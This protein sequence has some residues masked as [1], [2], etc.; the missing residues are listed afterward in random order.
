[1]TPFEVLYG[2]RCCT[3]LNWIE[4]GEN[5]IF[6]PNLIYEAEATIRHIQDNLK[7]T[8][9]CQESYANKRRW[10][11]EFEVGDHVYLRVSSTKGVK[12]FGMKGHLALRYI[13]P[14]P[15]LEKYGPVTYKLELPRAPYQD[16]GLK[17]SCHY[18]QYR[19]QREA[20]RARCFNPIATFPT[21]SP[22]FCMCQC[23]TWCDVLACPSA[24]VTNAENES[25]CH[26]LVH[27]PPTCSVCLQGD[28]NVSMLCPPLSPS[29]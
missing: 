26:P 12:R 13:G 28:L 21:V 19:H 11:L 15:K 6:G 27:R 7:A 18:A 20:D 3:T 25:P 16:F 1:M 17:V 24:R 22:S 10:P 23:A 2:R 29:S 14:F 4:L 8:R 5:V 9:S